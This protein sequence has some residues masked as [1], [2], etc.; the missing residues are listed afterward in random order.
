MK[1]TSKAEDNNNNV[2]NKREAWSLV[3]VQ[4]IREQ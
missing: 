3:K 4:F 1:F 2:Y